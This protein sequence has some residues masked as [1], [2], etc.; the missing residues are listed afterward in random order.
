MALGA[1]PTTCCIF[2]RDSIKYFLTK[3]FYLIVILWCVIVCDVWGFR[4]IFKRVVII[5]IACNWWTHHVVRTLSAR[6]DV[7]AK[8]FVIPC[9]QWLGTG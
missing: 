2:S 6:R 4:T 9:F 8:M 7:N 1:T 5:F 3:E